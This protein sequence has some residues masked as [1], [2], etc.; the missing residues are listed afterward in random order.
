MRTRIGLTATLLLLLASPAAA[1]KH[2]LLGKWE[3]T[4]PRPETSVPD[5]AVYD[6][7]KGGEVWLLQTSSGAAKGKHNRKWG[8]WKQKAKNLF[9]FQSGSGHTR[10]VFA[11]LKRDLIKGKFVK[12]KDR[13]GQFVFGKPFVEKKDEE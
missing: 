9:M 11:F 6:F 4:M 1:G 13:E 8:H 12:P 5:K 3:F 10:I 7:R 2:P